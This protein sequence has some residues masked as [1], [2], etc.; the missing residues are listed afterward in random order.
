[1]IED[2]IRHSLTLEPKVETYQDFFSHIVNTENHT[3]N[4]ELR[5]M[6][7]ENIGIDITKMYEL[8][9]K[10]LL[11]DAPLDL[12][13]Y[14]L[15]M[16]LGREPQDRFY[17]PRRDTL[18]D[19]VQGIQ[20]LADDK[21]D[22]L[23]LSEPPRV[24]KALANDT[25]IL[26]RNGWKN[27]G[28]LVVG[29]EVI[30]MDGKFKKVI[31]VHPKC[32]LDRLVE[33]SNGEKIQCH[34]RHEWM[35]Y[36]KRR[37]MVKTKETQYWEN[38]GLSIGEKG[39]RGHRYMVQVPLKDIV[40]GEE[41]ELPMKPYTFGVWLG[42]GSNM[43]P[44]ICNAKN[45]CAILGGILHDGYVPTARH[46]HN[47]T[48]VYYWDFGFRSELRKMGLCHS[49]HREDKY[50]PEEYLTASIEQRLD[51]LAGLIDTDGTFV[52]NENRYHFTTSEETLKDSFVQL[53]STF[54]WR[55][56]V[57]EVEPRTSTSGI[58]AR[59]KH[60]KCGFN[61]TIEIPC[62][63]ERKQNHKFSKQRRIGVTS[64][65]KVE[66]KEG[67]CITVE[68]DGMYLAGHTMIPTHNT[69]LLLFAM[70]WLMGRRPEKT[71]LYSAYSDTITKAFYEGINEIITDE[72]TYRFK[73]VFPGKKIA[74][75]NA[76][77]ETMDI[78]RR[79][80]YH[81]LTC[82]SLYGTLNGACDCS[83]LLMADDLIGSIEEAMNNDRLNHTWEKVDNNFIPRAK[84]KAK[85]LWCGTRWSLNDPSGRRMALLKERPE[86]KDR[87]WK[88]INLPALN[89]NDESN[90]E[91]KFGVGFST[92]YYKQ[93]RASFEHNDDMA[94][95]LAQ[96]MGEPIEREG[97][98]FS[99]IDFRYYNG[100]LPE[101]PDRIFMAVD[102]A[103]GGG[104]YVASPIVYQYGDDFYVDDVVYSNEDKKV[105]QP[106][107]VQ[108]VIKHDV[109][110][111][112][113]E[114]NK[115]TESYKEGVE[116]EIKAKGHHI[117]II[118]KPAPN[119]SSKEQ[120]IFDAAPDIR[121]HFIFRDSGCRTKEYN[122][123][124]QNVFGFKMYGKNKHDD[125]PDSL[126]MARDMAFRG[127]R[128]VEVFKRP[129]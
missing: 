112:Q 110:A 67:N 95:W 2:V 27:H 33:F 129:F 121:D 50:I 19:V 47:A 102:P 63:L 89:E 18:R 72:T 125:A 93:R 128:R 87:R 15:Y 119:N 86:Y 16:E 12:D 7:T 79:K 6:I 51:L 44:R 92:D 26:T 13:C 108:K 24:G 103:F 98:L 85:I 113:I 84:E 101:N 100:V 9:E 77:D 22:E 97:T 53:I 109:Q 58:V 55:V 52:K 64:I 3:L 94:S 116:K 21:L 10:T 105:T 111:L 124:M 59:K 126:A 82:R 45:D 41:K 80:R 123:F 75:Q 78:G 43:Q 54:G 31:A 57:T 115:S 127:T 30:G 25:P 34:Y 96:Y 88:V 68:G 107:I 23:F 90:F 76:A 91:Y 66:P 42:D 11:F 32:Q 71:N 106:L 74:F 39:K 117:N 8:Y 5:R 29:D 99:P 118:S 14:L 104:D 20:D 60:Y 73:E 70:T 1:M 28:D 61:P 48:G 122:L 38:R 65:T 69:T 83:G 4:K 120:R 49:R 37:G 62:R 46:I 40:E 36:D 81:T 35:F 17:L 56:S 114:A